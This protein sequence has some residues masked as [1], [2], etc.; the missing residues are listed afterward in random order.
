MVKLD[1]KDRKILYELD[2]NCRQSN[3]QIGKKV[4][5]KRDVVGYRI[6]NL[7]ENGIIKNFYTEIDTF[8]LGYDVFRIY[9]NFQ[10]I[11]TEIKEE[12]I[13][14][15][16]NYKNSWVVATIKSEIDLDV[17]V[18][19]KDIFEFYQ[20]WEKTLDKYEDFFSKYNI[21]IYV[22]ALVYKKSYL[23]DVQP[24]VN[25]RQL[26]EIH[27]SSE[28]VNIDEVDY[29]L[30]NELTVNARANLVDLADKLNCSS[31]SISYRIKNLEKFGIIKSFRVN[32][33]LSKLALQNFKVDIYLKEHKLKRPIIK[34]LETKPYIQFMNIAIGW[35][36]LEP[37]FVVKNFN[38]LVNILDEINTIFSGAIK[39]QSFFIADRLYKLR[40]LPDF[41][42]INRS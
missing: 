20:F 18:W 9:I 36:D 17:V 1:L 4:G 24:N 5:L 21:S 32:I 23:L 26:F 16:V 33:E 22:K 39:K 38:E 40:S 6:K 2:L 12:I 19:V 7:Q 10:Y 41:Y 14:Y 11:T 3:S 31:Q 29:L 15:F 42:R 27:C 8:K 35:A 13:K 37:E 25:N 34:Y 30:L 28:P